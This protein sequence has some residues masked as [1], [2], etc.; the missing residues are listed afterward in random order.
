MSVTWFDRSSLQGG[1][2]CI[3]EL[4]LQGGSKNV[5]DLVQPGSNFCSLQERR[6]VLVT[7]ELA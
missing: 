3:G 7:T 5:V 1:L 2:S 4:S 6:A